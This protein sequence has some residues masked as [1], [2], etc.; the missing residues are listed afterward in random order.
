MEDKKRLFADFSKEEAEEIEELAK[1]ARVAKT[2]IIRLATK[3]GL[4]DV[5]RILT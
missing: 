1:R 5:E 4:R 3:Q 2:T